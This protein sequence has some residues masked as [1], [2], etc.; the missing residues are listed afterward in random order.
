MP[1]DAA[2]P[3]DRPHRP[4]VV[5]SN[6]GPV[7][8][9]LGDGGGLVAK[10]GAGGLVSGIGPL[11]VDT[12]AT[13]IAAAMSDGDRIAA[14]QGVVEAEGFRVRT[15]ALDPEQYRM[16]YDVVSN[17]TLWFVHHHLYELARRPRFDTRWREAWDAYRAINEAFARVIVDEA[18]PDA[19]V[20]VQDY[21]LALVGRTVHAERPDVRTA[22]FSHTPFAVPD[23]FAV[24]PDDVAHEYLEGMA[25]FDAC[26]FHTT[27]WAEAFAGCCAQHAIEAPTTFVSPLATDEADIR[28]VAASA[29]C[30][31]AGRTLRDAIG[32]RQLIARVD[33]IELSKNLLR[34]F[35]AYE[36]LL[37]RWPEWRERVVFGAFVYASR[38][39]LAEYLAY[40]Q[41]VETLVTRINARWR[42]DTWTP[43]LLDTGDDFPASVAALRLYDVLLVNPIRDGLN[44]VATE[45]CLVNE[46]DGVLLL[47]PEAGAFE[48][49]GEAV[50]RVN[51]FDV[52]ST[53]AALHEALSMAPADRATHARRL[54][55]L[56]EARSPG[57]WLREQRVAAET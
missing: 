40:R 23:L 6:R 4:L 25:A 7:T 52:A 38:E 18:P 21:H 50:V 29:A 46:N 37:E 26:G 8:F 44:L 31:E 48:R 36:D 27:R 43:I 14:E 17:A 57:D 13:W 2:A 5:V 9:R 54:R 24:L 3:S 53:A 55:S 56:A 34:G 28:G 33:R 10:R 39:G 12:D 15:L 41:E 16:A 51:P 19:T 45:G 47:S 35:L 32:D 20:L 1:T 49:L 11:L 30:Q 42:T 22:H